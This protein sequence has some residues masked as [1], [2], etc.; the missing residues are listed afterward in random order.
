MPKS[1]VLKLPGARLYYELY[2]SGSIL[3][4]IPS[5]PTDAGV[6]AAIAGVLADRFT[7]VPYDPRGNSRSILDDRAEDQRMDQHGDD[8]AA[9][10]A[11]LGSQPAYVFGSSGGAQIS[12]N[13]AARYPERVRILIAHEPPCLELLPDAA[14]QRALMDGVFDSYR[15]EGVGPAMA[16]FQ[17]GAG[18]G[19]GPQAEPLATMETTETMGRIAD[20]MDFFLAHDVKPLSSYVPDIAALRKGSTRVVVGIGETSKGQLAHRTALALAE[21]LGNVAEGFPGGHAGY[22]GNPIVFA[23]K[24]H[25]VIQGE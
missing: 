24:L 25:H 23:D 5:G 9:L 12:L 20:N 18:L 6:F 1:Q 21:H 22:G 10:L 2:A 17:Q 8:A 15:K 13:L 4:M 7:V 3:M 19:V 14:E 11:A 16:R